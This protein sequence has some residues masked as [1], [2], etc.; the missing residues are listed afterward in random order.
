MTI[1]ELINEYKTLPKICFQTDY[2]NKK[3]VRANNKAVT[4]MYEIVETINKKFDIIGTEQF[5]K[6]LDTTDYK[7][8]IWVAIHLLEKLEPDQINK[9]KALSIINQIAKSNDPDA[10]A[11]NQ[12]LKDWNNKE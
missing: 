6:L 10:F 8:N 3:S 4:R 5:Q 9:T 2:S 7:T 1:D 11:F 12:W